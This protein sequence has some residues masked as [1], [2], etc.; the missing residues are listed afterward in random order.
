MISYE[1]IYLMSKKMNESTDPFEY[2]AR[3][4][5]FFWSRIVANQPL[6]VKVLDHIAK[7]WT[8]IDILSVTHTHYVIINFGLLYTHQQEGIKIGARIDKKRYIITKKLNK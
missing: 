5:P 2:R 3:F 7:C 1:T 4:L 6:S 8:V